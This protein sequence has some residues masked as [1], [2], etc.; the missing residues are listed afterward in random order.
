MATITATFTDAQ[1]DPAVG[2]VQF[3]PRG[4]RESVLAPAERS[5]G[6]VS[7]TRIRVPLDDG[8]LA[9]TLE[10][11]VYN[12]AIVLQYAR[13]IY[14]IATVPHGVA[15]IDLREL[16]GAYIPTPRTAGS[17][18]GN[19]GE[20]EWAIPAAATKIDVVLLGA[21]GGGD[22]GAVFVGGGGLAGEWL[23]ATLERGTDI[24]PATQVLTGTVGAGGAGGTVGAA[25]GVNGGASTL[26][27][28]GLTHDSAAGGLFTAAGGVHGAN[29]GT[30]LGI[31]NQL[32]SHGQGVTPRNFN[33]RD[34][35]GGGVQT[36]WGAAGN[37]P[38]G[39]G[40]GGFTL[41]PGGAGAAG[42]IWLTAY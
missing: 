11:G 40:S 42:R 3:E 9:V 33:S 26:T 39:G 16:L 41:S 4:L 37:G 2:Y 21:G 6:I 7:A 5:G 36:M 28:A 13:T 14:T 17:V 15:T 30:L 19:P 31:A 27:A 10:P 23:T 38:G 22:A 34:Y 25:S 32:I 24:P 8:E 20:F 35:P 18:F 1:G 29:K 12:V